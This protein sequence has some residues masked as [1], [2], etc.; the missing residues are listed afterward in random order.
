MCF[1]TA[2]LI[3]GVAGG[4]TSAV[5]A[6]TGGQATANA[7]NYQAQVARNNATIEGQ[8]ATYAEEAGEAQATATALKGASTAGKLKAG[9]AASGVDVNTGSTVA[10]QSGQKEASQLDTETVLNNADLQAYGYRTAAVSDE[11]T[12]GLEQLTAE[13]A[14]VGAD[15]GAAG[16]LLSSASAL[17]FKWQAAGGSNPFSGSNPITSPAVANYNSGN[18]I[19]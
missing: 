16:G 1:A 3:A 6:I 18:P 11:A 12:A 10:V 2:G 14:P 9:Q 15:I 7:A 17:G 13:E 19:S 8:N 4:L 5:G